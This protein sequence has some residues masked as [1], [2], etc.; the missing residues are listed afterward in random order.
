MAYIQVFAEE[1]NRDP[2]TQWW[3]SSRGDGTSLFPPSGNE[4]S[5]R[6]REVPYQSVTLDADELGSLPKKRRPRILPLPGSRG[7]LL[8][9]Y[10]L[11]KQ[12][13]APIGRPVTVAMALSTQ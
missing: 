1:P 8:R 5:I 3:Y 2:A 9:H 12:V 4:G 11:L 10:F 7:S 13:K 6:N